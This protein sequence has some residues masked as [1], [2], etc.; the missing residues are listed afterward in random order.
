MKRNK[1]ETRLSSCP[2][3]LDT[4][5]RCLEGFDVTEH[6]VRLR[7]GT[8]WFRRLHVSG[9]CLL[10][11]VRIAV[12]D[13][14]E[15]LIGGTE[16]ADYSSLLSSWNARRLRV[17][18]ALRL[19]YTCLNKTTRLSSTPSGYLPHRTISPPNSQTHNPL[20]P[21]QDS[22]MTFL[23]RHAKYN[24]IIDSWPKLGLGRTNSVGPDQRP[25]ASGRH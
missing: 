12:R 10:V 24:D 5:D 8:V 17:Y 11:S 3:K 20:T 22:P 2:G 7:D 25:A 14:S 9:T 4:A 13:C 6:R 18:S 15:M 16:Y 21:G 23:S 1:L 19:Q